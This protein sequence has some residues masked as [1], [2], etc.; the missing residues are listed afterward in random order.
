[1]GKFKN[2]LK[3]P[4]IIILLM[5]IVLAL[6][7]LRPNPW[8]E[9]A[10]IRSVAKNST[11][12][13]AGIENPKPDLPPMD[14]EVILSVN[15]KPV[16]NADDYYNIIRS[17]GPNMTVQ[18]KTTKRTYRMETREAF[19]T[20]YANGTE[21]RE[22]IGVEDLGIVVYDAPTNNIRKGL[23]LQG[24]T[25]VVLQPEK[26]LST[27]DMDIVLSNI[28]ERL[29][30]YGLSD[31]VV[32]EANDMSGNQFIIVEIAGATEEEVRNLI[33]SQGKFEA[34]IG[35]DTVFRGEGDITYVCKN[36]AQ[37]SGI[38][39]NVGCGR[40]EKGYVCRFRFSISLR[41]EAAQRQAELTKDLDIVTE[42]KEKYLSKKLDLYLDD[43][44]VD[45]LN[46]GA[47]LKGKAETEIAISGS[48][49]G[50]TEEEA[51]YDALKN[52]KRL[53]T[54]LLTGSLPVKINV[55]KMDSL[56]PIFGKDLI[57]NSLLIGLVALVA[58]SLCIFARYKRIELVV[59]I[60]MTS[61]LELLFM[62][63]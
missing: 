40:N 10:A 30:V 27:D 41:P 44:L 58:V 26:R 53:Q 28:K 60:I 50:I 62:M 37:C 45:T 59:P 22:S 16:K 6:Y 13:I 12:S 56:S 2:I 49:V 35:N 14:R 20:Y 23:D 36:N 38:D 55:V 51:I 17:I 9:G 47:D 42:N 39:P 11:A 57:K 21:V 43:V 34:K 4:R 7:V 24:G 3:H 18:I 31:I 33:A 1:M 54:I 52:M 19:R 15:N 5:C 46:I 63:G 25:R 32:R 29:N 61:L 48:G 8:H